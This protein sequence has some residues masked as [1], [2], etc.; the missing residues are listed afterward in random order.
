MKTSTKVALVTLVVGIL[1]FLTESNGP[2][3]TAERKAEQ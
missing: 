1:G 2:L 3:G